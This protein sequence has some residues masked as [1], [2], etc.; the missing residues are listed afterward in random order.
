MSVKINTAA[1]FE[2]GG[3][4]LM[5][6]VLGNAGTAITQASISTLA[7]KVYECASEEDAL[8]ADGDEVVG[9]G[10]SLTV[11]S[12]VYD[13]L[14]TASPWNSTTDATGYNF[15]YDVPA[16]H[17]PTGS[18]WYRFEFK[19]T[20]TSGAPFWVVWVVKAEPIATS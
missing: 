7:L 16:N 11:A 14:Q 18:R 6:R 10:G 12:Q 3:I 13:T 9:V 2:D 17:M 15:R 5:D 20:P 4:T 19:F 8:A 1:A